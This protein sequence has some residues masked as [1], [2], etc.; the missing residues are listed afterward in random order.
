VS[1]R[2]HGPPRQGGGPAQVEGRNILELDYPGLGKYAEELVKN[3]L[4]NISATMI[5]KLHQEIAGIK[6]SI[7]EE[8][9]ELEEHEM[10]E[11]LK[12]A[13]THL[14]YMLAYTYGRLERGRGHFKEYMETLKK[15]MNA[16]L[17]DR[18]PQKLK[19]SV[20]KLYMFS[21]AVVAYHK[22]HEELK[23]E[24]REGRA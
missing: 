15:T 24:E 22:Y 14:E 9:R 10:L 18:D 7:F 19:K 17:Q 13:F 6:R 12:K 16:I 8:G 11:E 5:R 4:I 2:G 23:K 3:K 21:E 1:F 20:E